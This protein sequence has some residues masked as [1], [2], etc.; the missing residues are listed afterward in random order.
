MGEV[1]NV[2]RDG[3]P[4]YDIMFED[5]FSKLSK[6]VEDLG[7]KGRRIAIITDSRG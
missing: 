3:Q 4:C 1:I 7:F 5:G 2:A 6:A